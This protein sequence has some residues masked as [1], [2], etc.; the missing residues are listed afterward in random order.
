MIEGAA[1]TPAQSSVL[2][3]E[4]LWTG[5]IANLLEPASGDRT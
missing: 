5:L 1:L 3:R 2:D 4:G